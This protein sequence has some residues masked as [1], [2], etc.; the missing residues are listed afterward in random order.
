[1]LH[2]LEAH[3]V[4]EEIAHEGD[5]V[6]TRAPSGDGAMPEAKPARPATVTPP[7]PALPTATP[8]D[9]ALVEIMDR[10]DDF[11]PD[12]MTPIEALMALAEL[13]KLSDR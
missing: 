1:V 5:E 4:A 9:P 6:S 13:K 11:D 10:L 2:H 12:R 8:T 7:A 3:N